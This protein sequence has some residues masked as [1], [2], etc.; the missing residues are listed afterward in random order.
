MVENIFDGY[1]EKMS[2]GGDD[3]IFFPGGEGDDEYLF[4]RR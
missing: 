1:G 2:T 3:E 4:L